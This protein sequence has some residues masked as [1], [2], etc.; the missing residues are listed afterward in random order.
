MN[1]F[2]KADDVTNVLPALANW[3]HSQDIDDEDAAYTCMIFV[4]IQLGFMASSEEGL[5]G[6]VTIS[7]EII[8]AKAES[9]FKK[10]QAKQTP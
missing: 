6:G 9:F 10:L 3:F 8:K 7:A 5:Q 1:K 4:G 2:I